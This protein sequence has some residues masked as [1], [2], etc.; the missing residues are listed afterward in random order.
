MHQLS[1]SKQKKPKIN[2]S[3]PI[4]G[5]NDDCEVSKEFKSKRNGGEWR[6]ETGNILDVSNKT[7]SIKELTVYEYTY[8]DLNY[9]RVVDSAYHFRHA[10]KYV[11]LRW[12]SNV[13][14]ME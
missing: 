5:E 12:E 9:R 3:I 4:S 1:Y 10:E 2:V 8:K 13:M 14:G 11:W 6:N 7:S